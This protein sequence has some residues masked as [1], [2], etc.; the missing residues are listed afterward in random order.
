MF[1]CI[2]N[3]L[4]KVCFNCIAIFDGSLYQLHSLLAMMSLFW[5]RSFGSCLWLILYLDNF[6]TWIEIECLSDPSRVLWSYDCILLV[7]RHLHFVGHSC[8]TVAQDNIY[9]WQLQC[10][11]LILQVWSKCC[12]RMTGKWCENCSYII[13]IS[14]RCCWHLWPQLFNTQHMLIS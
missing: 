11:K 1:I 5:P 13:L 14:H 12:T 6:D 7:S 8:I 3:L 10:H 4:E 9:N 2:G